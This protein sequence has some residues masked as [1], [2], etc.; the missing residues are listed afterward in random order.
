MEAD[1]WREGGDE[2]EERHFF[3]SRQRVFSFHMIQFVNKDDSIYSK[4]K[5]SLPEV[6]VFK[7]YHSPH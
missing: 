6:I 5:I 2:A 7:S 3:P 4:N 1:S